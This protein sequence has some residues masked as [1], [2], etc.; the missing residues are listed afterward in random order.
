[1]ILFWLS[2][3]FFSKTVESVI[4]LGEEKVGKG[5]KEGRGRDG[6]KVV[7]ICNENECIT[8]QGGTKKRKLKERYFKFDEKMSLL[9]L[10]TK[11]LVKMKEK[12]KENFPEIESLRTLKKENNE[13]V[14]KE[15][16]ELER[17]V[18]RSKNEATVGILYIK[19]EQTEEEEMFSNENNS[20]FQ[21]FYQ[22]L[23]KLE[24][25]KGRKGFAGGLNTKEDSTG[26]HSLFT[27]FHNTQIAFHVSTLINS[28]NPTNSINSNNSTNSINS[29]NSTNSI[30]SNPT[31]KI[32][33]YT[34]KL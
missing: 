23:G 13:K 27:S 17:S 28:N 29:N 11:T 21:N 19:K 9:H 24:E 8:F 30:N 4:F 5:G 12:I 14:K 20:H 3:S 22:Q 18:L 10:S 33:N 34:P 25:L 15:L 6:N 2:T 26:T 32:K 1:M 7:V 16:L 31:A